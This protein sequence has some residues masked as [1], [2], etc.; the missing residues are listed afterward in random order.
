MRYR[1]N[2]YNQRIAMDGP[3]TQVKPGP[4]NSHIKRSDYNSK[5]KFVTRTLA[6]EGGC[7]AE[8]AH[9]ANWARSPA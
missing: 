3:L 4:D 9:P 7:P 8:P 6:P 1:Y 2:G 5:T